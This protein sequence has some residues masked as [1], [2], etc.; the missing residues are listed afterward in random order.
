MATVAVPLTQRRE[1]KALTD[2]CRRLESVQLRAL[3]AD[4]PKRGQRFALEAGGRYLTTREQEPDV[5]AA[6]GI[7]DLRARPEAPGNRRTR[8]TWHGA[9]TMALPG[10]QAARRASDERQQQ[11]EGI[12]PLRAQRQAPSFPGGR[13]AT[14]TAGGGVSRPA[15]GHGASS[16]SPATARPCSCR[17]WWRGGCKCCGGTGARCRTPASDQTSWGT[18]AIRTAGP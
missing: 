2:R 10:W 7:V 5:R 3:C 6:H 8:T 14:S 15:S 4:D 9:T 17:T 11:A 13:R 18:A 16:P 1:W 12:A